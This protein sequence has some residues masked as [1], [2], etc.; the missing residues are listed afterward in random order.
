MKRK[1]KGTTGQ[2]AAGYPNR[3]AFLSWNHT[4]LRA[5]PTA[6]LPARQDRIP[7]KQ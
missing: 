5:Q 2:P 7:K 4:S 3:T 1:A 6:I